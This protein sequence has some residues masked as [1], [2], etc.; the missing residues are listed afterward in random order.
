MKAIVL[1]RGRI[2]TVED[3]DF[4]VVNQF[5]WHAVRDGKT[6]Y[7]VRNSPAVNGRRILLYQHSF[8]LGVKGV[9]H[10]DGDGLN[11]LRSNIRPA[12]QQQNIRSHRRKSTNA[13]SKYRGVCW[14]AGRQKW[15]TQAYKDAKHIYRGWFDNEEDAARAWDAAVSQ[16]YGEFA[17]LNFPL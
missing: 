1:T 5:K 12:T 16:H 14:D 3:T 10:K 11:N 4:D 9:D 13:T 17:T 2:A 15:L 6:Y 8:I 7:A